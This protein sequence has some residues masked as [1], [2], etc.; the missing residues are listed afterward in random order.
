MEKNRL[1]LIPREFAPAQLP[2]DDTILQRLEAINI[3][4]RSRMKGRNLENISD[5]LGSFGHSS[6]DQRSEDERDE[7]YSRNHGIEKNGIE[8]FKE[9]GRLS[10]ENG[11][12]DP[13]RQM[14]SR[15]NS[16]VS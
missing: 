16:F 14:G 3:T 15:K 6:D 1:D 8:E 4:H 11:L 9:S 2:I 5:S 7:K 12:R 10:F 13:N